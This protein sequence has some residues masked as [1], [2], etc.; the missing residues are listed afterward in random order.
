MSK[1]SKKSTRK[2]PLPRPSYYRRRGAVAAEILAGDEAWEEAVQTGTIIAE[3]G[4]S[5]L[6]GFDRVRSQPQRFEG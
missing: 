4:W 3:T 5:F 2:N 1:Q 6:R